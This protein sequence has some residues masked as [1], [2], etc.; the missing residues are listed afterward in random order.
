MDFAT[1]FLAFLFLFD[2]FLKFD[3]IQ[4]TSVRQKLDGLGELEEIE[5]R[6]TKQRATSVTIIFNKQ[7]K[8]EL[9]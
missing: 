2:Y 7:E 5:G 1:S 9:I 6:E 4:A 3:F 8:F